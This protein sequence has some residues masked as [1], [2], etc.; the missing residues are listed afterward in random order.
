MKE[1][2]SVVWWGWSLQSAECRVQSY[3]LQGDSLYYYVNE[4]VSERVGK[5]VL[6]D[7]EGDEMLFV[8]SKM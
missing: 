8:F 1:L 3:R 5:R 4:S 7:V 2:C 6:M